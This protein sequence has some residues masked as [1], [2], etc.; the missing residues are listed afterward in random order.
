MKLNAQ[1]QIMLGLL[2]RGKKRVIYKEL[3]EILR[4][5][6]L[7]LKEP[8]SLKSLPSDCI[9]PNLSPKKI[10]RLPLLLES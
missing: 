5:L 9:I 6:E 2:I 3:R 7:L 8:N 1:I 10:G 4:A